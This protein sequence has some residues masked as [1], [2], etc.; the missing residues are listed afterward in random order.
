MIRINPLQSGD[1]PYTI[2]ADNPFAASADPTVLKEIYAYGFRNPHTYSFNR[3]DSGEVH[4]LLGDI[5]RNNVEEVNLVTPGGNFGWTKREGS[6][7]HLQNPDGPAAGYITGLSELPAEEATLGYVYPAAQYDHDAAIGQVSSGNSVAS[8]FFIRNG[9]D[10][11][12]HNQ[13]LFGDLSRRTMNNVFHADLNDLLAAVTTLGIDDVDRNEP[14]ELTQAAVHS[15]QLALD[16]DNDP[17]TAAQ[18][19]DNFLELLQS[20]TAT[21]RTDIRFGE[22]AFGEMYISSKVNGTIYLVTNSV[23]V[24]GDFDADGVVS[25]SDFM[26]WQREVGQSET[27]SPADGNR[28]DVVDGLDNEI[29]EAHF[30]ERF[31]TSVSP[32]SVVPEPATVAI[33]LSTI[34]LGRLI[35]RTCRRGIR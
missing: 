17:G 15:L 7:V 5:G 23:P 2:P 30:G 19:F 13:F 8:G 14:G 21:N 35:R 22:G 6:F 18:L 31:S 33:V 26:L 10:A 20:S 32:G 27:E 34:V 24:P 25:G 29:W 9:S 1:A 11:N 28:D 3:D 12:L 4:I 16:H